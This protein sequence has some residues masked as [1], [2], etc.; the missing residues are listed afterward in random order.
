MPTD[1]PLFFDEGNQRELPTVPEL[2]DE[3]LSKMPERPLARCNRAK[4]MAGLKSLDLVDDSFKLKLAIEA[5]LLDPAKRTI[6][7]E[8]LA[9]GGPLIFLAKLSTAVGAYCPPLDLMPG[10]VAPGEPM[11]TETLPRSA[12]VTPEMRAMTLAATNNFAVSPRGAERKVPP[13]FIRGRKPLRPNLR[14]MSALYSR[15]H[16]LYPPSFLEVINLKTILLCEGLTFDHQPGSRQ[17]RRDVPD[18]LKG[19]LYMDVSDLQYRRARHCF[20]HELWHM[21][22]LKLRGEKFEAFDAAWEKFNPPGFEY[23]DGDGHIGGG[24]MRDSGVAELDSAP[25]EHFLNKYSTSSIAEDKAEVWACM[26]CYEHA[27]K[28]EPLRR[29]AE[30]IRS[31]VRVLCAGLDEDWWKLVRWHQLVE[32][33]EWERHPDPRLEDDDDESTEDEHEEEEE[34]EGEEEEVPTGADARADAVAET[35]A[36]TRPVTGVSSS[37]KLGAAKEDTG[38]GESSSTPSVEEEEAEEDEEELLLE[39]NGD[40]GASD[41]C[42]SDGCELILE[43]NPQEEKKPQGGSGSGDGSDDELML[44]ENGPKE[45]C[46]SDDDGLMLEENEEGGEDGGRAADGVAAGPAAGEEEEEEL[47]LEVNGEGEAEAVAAVAPALL[48]AKTLTPSSSTKQQTVGQQLA[49]K[50]EQQKKQQQQQKQQT[51]QKQQK[52][53]KPNLLQSASQPSSKGST[54]KKKKQQKVKKPLPKLLP[55]GVVY[56][57]FVTGKYEQAPPHCSLAFP[58]Q[59]GPCT[60]LERLGLGHYLPAF[61]EDGYDD[62][63]I[64][65]EISEAERKEVLVDEL[66][67]RTA[68]AKKLTHEIFRLLSD[69]SDPNER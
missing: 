14:R 30:L 21:A 41:G 42:E 47:T 20:H 52:Q 46:S 56:R 67:M 31:R 43:D 8:A 49:Q 6:L 12:V 4:I 34:G 51:Q 35:A 1:V 22:D 60:L 48:L 69:L 11:Q 64:L 32:R 15:E 53:Q 58:K 33:K 45:E 17:V 24:H 62:L 38:S 65:R 66:N 27:L 54:K 36:M 16:A 13:V 57:S 50:L 44:E 26:M 29:K 25:S 9:E 7:R 39:N 28:S 61:E 10:E 5:S 55:R 2:V 68:D 18:M 40:D 3:T 59:C 37:S 63:S 23:G 19:M